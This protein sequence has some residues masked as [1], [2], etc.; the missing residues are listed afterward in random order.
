VKVG[1]LVRY[2]R[3]QAVGFAD[4]GIVLQLPRTTSDLGCVKVWCDGEVRTWAYR[5]CEVVSESR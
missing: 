4:I 1:D 2:T 5:T 3:A